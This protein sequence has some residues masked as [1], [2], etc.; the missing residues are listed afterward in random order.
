MDSSPE[1][2]TVS[3]I[4]KAKTSPEPDNINDIAIDGGQKSRYQRAR[5]FSIDIIGRLGE[6]L[7]DGGPAG[8]LL[9]YIVMGAVVYST[10]VALGEMGTML[11]VAGQTIHYSCRFVDP[12]LGFA[13]G[14]TYWYSNGITLV[15][16]ITS[17]SEG[18]EY[19]TGADYRP[20]WITIFLVSTSVYS[21]VAVKWHEKVEVPNIVESGLDTGFFLAPS[22]NQILYLP[23][24]VNS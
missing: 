18:L 2:K 6:A 8:L 19:W 22:G 17:A 16:E 9:G 4:E 12:A 15:M 10:I 3:D 11:P 21:I 23:P 24:S 13:L 7:S 14:W 5:H 1:N 20:L